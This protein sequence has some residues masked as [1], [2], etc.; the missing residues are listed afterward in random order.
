MDEVTS[1]LDL[2]SEKEF[3]QRICNKDLGKTM[4]IVSHRVKA[5]ENC[6]E[7]FKLENRKL[8]KLDKS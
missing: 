8:K 2:E 1:S 6:D 5:L 4:I 3:I 7:I